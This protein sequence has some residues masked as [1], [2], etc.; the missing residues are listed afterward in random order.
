MRLWRKSLK[1]MFTSI[2]VDLTAERCPFGKAKSSKNVI[3]NILLLIWRTIKTRNIYSTFCIKQAKDTWYS[4]KRTLASLD[5]VNSLRALIRMRGINA[6]LRAVLFACCRRA[7]EAQ[8]RSSCVRKPS[9]ILEPQGG[10]ISMAETTMD[11][12]GRLYSRFTLLVPDIACSR[13]V[14]GCGNVRNIQ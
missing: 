5:N 3:G 9:V 6:F 8:I 14:V 7:D 12:A 13:S 10:H 11:N 1:T 4:Y 2:Q